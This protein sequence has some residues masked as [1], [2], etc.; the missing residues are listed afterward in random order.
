MDTVQYTE[1]WVVGC[2][3]ASQT[4]VHPPSHLQCSYNHCLVPSCHTYPHMQSGGHT[5][6]TVTQTEAN[7]V[8]LI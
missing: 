3:L 1:I 7:I 2:A 5:L 6:Y 8:K 4:E